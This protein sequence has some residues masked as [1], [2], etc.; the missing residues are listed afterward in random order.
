VGIRETLNQNP[1]IT[2]GAT[3]GIIL[4]ALIFII[5]QITGSGGP[6]VATEAFYTTDDGATWFA[7]EADKI[8]PFDKDG[9]QA[10]RVYVY[11]CK[12]GDEFISHLERYT[13]EAKKKLEEMKT[14]G[15]D[16][17]ADPGMMEMIYMGGVEVKDPKTGDKGWVKQAQF[18]QAAKITT[19][20]C[21]DGTSDT[22]EPVMP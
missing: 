11:K 9:K 20:V 18:E 5:W 16:A 2:T 7:D 17:Q 8:P 14:K 12:D 4:L 3:A 22:L 1:G 15:P 10:Y 13:P 21:P 6:S 19:P